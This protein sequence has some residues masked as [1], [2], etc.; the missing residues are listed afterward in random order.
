MYDINTHI[1]RAYDIRGIV[2]TDLT[3]DAVELIG[4]AFGSQAISQQQNAVVIARDGRLSSPELAQRLAKGIRSTGLKV[5]DVGLVPTPVLSLIHI[6][7]P[8]RRYAIS[9]AVFCL[10]KKR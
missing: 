6:S 7:E 5:I 4:R 2:S 8:T 3:P 1:F 10:K 9:Y